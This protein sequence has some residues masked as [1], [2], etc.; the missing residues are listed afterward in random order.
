MVLTELQLGE[1]RELTLHRRGQ[2]IVDTERHLEVCSNRAR[3]LRVVKRKLAGK[4]AGKL[5]W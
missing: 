2:R 4:L 5:A 1:A 3:K